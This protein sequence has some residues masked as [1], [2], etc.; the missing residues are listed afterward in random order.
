MD[1]LTI[2][3]NQLKTKL[4]NAV[5]ALNI[6]N[7]ELV[8]IVKMIQQRNDK[9]DEAIKKLPLQKVTLTLVKR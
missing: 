7:M 2:Q 3:N 6:A 8:A 4:T 5:K 9:I 1:T